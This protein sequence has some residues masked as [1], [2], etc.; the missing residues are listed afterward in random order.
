MSNS[1]FAKARLNMVD[2]QILPNRVTDDNVVRAM[3]SLP[4]EVFLPSSAHSLAY[5]D[6]SVLIED[7][8]YL[9]Q[10]MVLAR[11]LD[12]AEIGKSDVALSIGCGS[13]YEIAVLAR[14]V[15]TVVAIEP[16]G[17]MRSKAEK[18]LAELQIDNVVIVDG[19]FSEGNAQEAPFDLIFISGAVPEIPDTVARQLSDGG[20]L[21]AI[22][23]PAGKPVG[24][25]VLM[26]R[27]GDAFS[28]REVFDAV[29]P[30]LPGFEKE[31]A[32]SF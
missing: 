23:M 11:L 4:R 27:Y 5:A 1:Q 6:D 15:D 12:I 32:F 29:E 13:G 17:T 8:R 31:A 26:T 9:M 3:G 25:G 24:R 28:K 22:E 30:V 21:V 18:N 7:G 14:L 16:S 19:E 2:S 20:R 10:P